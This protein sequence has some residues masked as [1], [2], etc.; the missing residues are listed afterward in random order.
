MA[1]Y[2]KTI[3]VTL[4]NIDKV[5]AGQ[6]VNLGGSRGQYL[7]KTRTGIVAVRWQTRNRF[8]V[9]DALNN[10]VVREFAVRNGSK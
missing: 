7:G 9:S 3:A 2:Q 10:Q 8:T 4:G 6:W 1:K 5:Q